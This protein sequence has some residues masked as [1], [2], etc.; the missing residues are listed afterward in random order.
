MSMRRMG[1]SGHV[2]PNKYVF[3]IKWLLFCPWRKFSTLS[4]LRDKK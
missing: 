4:Y 2:K 3:K 1:S